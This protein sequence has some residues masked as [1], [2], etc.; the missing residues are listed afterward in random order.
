MNI[1]KVAR[2]IKNEIIKKWGCNCP[3]YICRTIAEWIESKRPFIPYTKNFKFTIEKWL[4]QWG[5]NMEEE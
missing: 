2:N 5:K 1:E 3:L 4:D